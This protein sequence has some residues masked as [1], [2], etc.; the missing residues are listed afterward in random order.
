MSKHI[1]KAKCP[2]CGNG[3]AKL[4]PTKGIARCTKCCTVY[5]IIFY[6][7]RRVDWGGSNPPD[8]RSGCE[9]IRRFES[10]IPDMSGYRLLNMMG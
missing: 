7:L 3:N 1:V 2:E 4:I 8:S 6:L 10:S 5:E 9:G